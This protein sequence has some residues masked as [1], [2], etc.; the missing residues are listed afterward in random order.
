[1]N[2]SVQRIEQKEGE[3]FVKPDLS[4]KKTIFFIERFAYLIL[5][6]DHGKRIEKKKF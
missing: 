3:Y 5:I 4:W 6:I 2:I 1:M